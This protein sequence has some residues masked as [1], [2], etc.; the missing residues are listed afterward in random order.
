MVGANGSGKT[1]FGTEIEKTYANTTHRVSAQKSLSMPYEVN[2]KSKAEYEF[3][4][5]HWYDSIFRSV[6]TTKIS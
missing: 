3:Y 4:Y 5:G 6:S 1:R 2:S